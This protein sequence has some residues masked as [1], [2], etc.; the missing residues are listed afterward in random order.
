ML[1]GGRKGH[2]AAF[3]WRAGRMNC[4]VQLRETVRDV[5]YVRRRRSGTSIIG[6]ARLWNVQRRT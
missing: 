3:D 2:V 1:I 6:A 4:E 5:Q